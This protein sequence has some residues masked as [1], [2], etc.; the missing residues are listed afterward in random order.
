MPR[1]P[2]TSVRVARVARMAMAT[3]GMLAALLAAAPAWAGSLVVLVRSGSSAALSQ[4]AETLLAAELR[5]AGFE[6]VPVA[7]AAGVDVRA[8]LE[9]A[10]GSTATSPIATIA[11]LPSTGAAAFDAWISDRV[12][13]KLVVRRLE[14]QGA[15]D[16]QAAAD[17]ALKA[18]ELLRGSLLEI[19]IE[20]PGPQPA[21]DGAAPAD[22]ARFVHQAHAAREDW[23]FEGVGLGLG[24]SVVRTG[25]RLGA[26]YLPSLRFSFGGGRGLGVRLRL[27]AFGRAHEVS[28]AEG[29]AK[30]RPLFALV[31]A[32]KS[33]RPRAL[34]Q[35]FL[36]AGAGAARVAVEGTGVSRL[37]VGHQTSSTSAC[38]S[39]GVG[40]AVRL[41]RSAALVVET[42][43]LFS[44][45]STSVT[46]AGVEAARAGGLAPAASAG[47]TTVF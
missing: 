24:A 23:A 33:F 11:L 10:A 46:I 25:T 15:G 12:T 20:R 37:F 42:Q 2:T 34:L 27:D 26:A 39:A 8:Q 19:R 18:M 3:L 5:A 32:H 40:L 44:A 31:E 7:R 21:R 4:Q 22:V 35:P 36:F 28:A 41:F 13:G 38:G 30:V 45:P 14:V 29:L 9:S 6:V 1:R 17:L 47:V 43:L 16:E